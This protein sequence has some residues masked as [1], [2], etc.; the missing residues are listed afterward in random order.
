MGLKSPG[1]GR[2]LLIFLGDAPARTPL[3][4]AHP[5]P[6]LYRLWRV[7]VTPADVQAGSPLW[8]RCGC[9]CAG[10]VG[11]RVMGIGGGGRAGGKAAV[12]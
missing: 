4:P 7:G 9:E 2:W 12:C 11:G 3:K 5:L 10:E 8:D 6:C 1:R